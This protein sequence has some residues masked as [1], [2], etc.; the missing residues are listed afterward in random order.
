M[1]AFGSGFVACPPLKDMRLG[2]VPALAGTVHSILN[3]GTV[4]M[5][6]TDMLGT[7]ILPGEQ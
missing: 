3:H 6:Y 7:V 1:T 4:S 2:K 5:V